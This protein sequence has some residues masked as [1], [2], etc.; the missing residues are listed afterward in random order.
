MVNIEGG[1]KNYHQLKAMHNPTKKN[2]GRAMRV[3]LPCEWGR[4]CSTVA[5][6]PKHGTAR[7]LSPPT[8]TT[9]VEC[10]GGTGCVHRGVAQARHCKSHEH[11]GKGVFTVATPRHGTANHQP[12]P[13]PPPPSE[14]PNIR[15]MGGGGGQGVITKSSPRHGTANHQPPPPLRRTKQTCNGEGG[16]HG[17]FIVASFKQAQKVSYLPPPNFTVAPHKHGTERRPSPP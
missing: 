4:H 10:G 6:S 14:E 3:T 9:F 12:P 5:A 13:P 1:K 7:C 17:V 8:N 15:V 16:G 11:R 2:R